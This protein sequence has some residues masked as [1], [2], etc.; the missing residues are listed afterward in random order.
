MLRCKEVSQ[1]ISQS[2]DRNLSWRE[3][4]ALRLHLTICKH[5]SR[6]SQQLRTLRVALKRL[7]GHVEN[8]SSI[9]LSSDAK[10][11]ISRSIESMVD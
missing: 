1:L 10:A 7:C 3:R 2:L 8:D 5:C 6:F 11:R 9:T 4:F